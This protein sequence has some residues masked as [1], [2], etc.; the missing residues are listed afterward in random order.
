MAEYIAALEA[1][2]RKAGVRLTE[3]QRTENAIDHPVTFP[4]GAYLKA[5]YGRVAKPRG[6]T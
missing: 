3:M 4:Q 6:R 1:G 2:A 5:Y